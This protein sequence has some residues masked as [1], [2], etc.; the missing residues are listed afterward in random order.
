MSMTLIIGNKNYSSW[1]FRGWLAMKLSGVPFVEHLVPLGHTT[2]PGAPSNPELLD[3]SAAGKVPVLKDGELLVWDSLAI[4]EYLA[5]RAPGADLWPGDR[6]A[7]AR[8]RSISA[9]MHA[10]FMALRGEAPMNMRRAVKPLLLS[11]SAAYDVTR[12]AAIWREALASS[13]GPF[14]FGAFSLA[15]AMYAPVV[16]RF[17]VYALSDD[18]VVRAYMDRMMAEPLWQEWET[19]ARAEEWVIA[20]EEV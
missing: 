10:G 6:V 5:E 15:D 1:S 2:V 9:E 11:D 18:P 13:G 12:I 14:L 20:A 17:H 4:F 16:N 8:A 19:A 3:H 7:R